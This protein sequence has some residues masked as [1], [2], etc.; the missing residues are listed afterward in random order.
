ML[1]RKWLV[2]ILVTMAL[3]AGATHVASAQPQQP[4]LNSVQALDYAI[5]PGGIILLRL[6]FRLALREPPAVLAGYH[7]TAHITLDFSATASE[8]SKDPVEVNQRGL[9]SLQVIQVGTRTRLI[10]SLVSP[11]VY[12]TDSKGRELLIT[13]QRPEAATRGA[14]TGGGPG[15][16]P[17]ARHSVHNVTFERGDAGEGRII[18]ELSGAALPID[19][20]R[21]GKALIVDFLDSALPSRLERRLDVLDFG[22]PVQ[23]IETF[24]VGNKT[25]LKI[26]LEGAAEYSAY[27]ISRS[28]VVSTQVSER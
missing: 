5:L 28:F 2:P 11:H 19:V 3:A 10:V 12:E 17:E 20:R 27:Q 9:R 21:Q 18:V 4:A 16:A 23:A 24:R 13:L 6:T 1:T 15:G 14:V 7:P 8:V 26:E 25:R 22:T